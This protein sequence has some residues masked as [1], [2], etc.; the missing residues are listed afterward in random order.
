MIREIGWGWLAW[1]AWSLWMVFIAITHPSPWLRGLCVCLLAFHF[2][3]AELDRRVTNRLAEEQRQ[4]IS[5]LDIE[6][7]PT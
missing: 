6:R 2:L 5:W 1:C 7:K 4:L 3:V